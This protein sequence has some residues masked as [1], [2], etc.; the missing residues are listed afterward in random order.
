MF[1]LPSVSNALSEIFVFE[2]CV[3]R[4]KASVQGMQYHNADMSV[5]DYGSPFEQ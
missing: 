5:I 2:S 3:L 1:L 4:Q